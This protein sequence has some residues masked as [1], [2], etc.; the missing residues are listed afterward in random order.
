MQGQQTGGMIQ[1]RGCH[2]DVRVYEKILA[3]GIPT[4]SAGPFSIRYNFQLDGAGAEDCQR[5]AA[6]AASLETQ[7]NTHPEATRAGSA[8]RCARQFKPGDGSSVR[9]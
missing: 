5:H 8:G 6:T 1:T 7:T 2:D 9:D 4:R 3:A